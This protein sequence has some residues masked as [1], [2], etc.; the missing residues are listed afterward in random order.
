MPLD[1]A[2]PTPPGRGAAAASSAAL[3]LV[4]RCRALPCADG[5][6][7]V[8]AQSRAVSP[9]EPAFREGVAALHNFEYED[10]NAAFLRAQKA[11]PG[12]AMAYWGEAMTYH[13]S[14]WR[15]EDVAAGR[16][17]LARLAARAP[18]AR[19]ATRRTATERGFSAPR[20]SSSAR[21]MPPRAGAATPRRWPRL[22]ASDARRPRR[23]LALRARAARHDVAQPDRLRRTAHEGHSAVARRQRDADA[24]RRDS[25]PACCGRTREHPGALHY[26]LH[27]Y[28]DP[29]HARLGLDAARA[30][31]RVA[32]ESS[33]ALHM[34]AH[35]FL[36]LGMWAD[37]E[38]LGSRRLRR[39]GGVGRSARGFAPAMRSYHALAW[40]QYE[41]LQLGRFSEAAAAHRRDR[42]GGEGDRR[43]DAAER[44][45]LDARALRGRDPPLGACM[46]SERNFGN[47]NELCAIGFSAAR[48]GNPALAE[49]ARGRRWPA[50]PPRPRKATCGRPSPSWSAR[51]R[52]D[53]ARRP[54]A[55]TRRSQ[56][57]RAATR[58]RAAAAAAAGP[59]DPDQARRRS[60]SARCCSSWAGRPRRSTPFGAG[61][62]AQRQPHAV[63]A[64]L[65]PGRGARSGRPTRRAGTTRRCWPT[66]SSADADLP[67][68]AEARA[69]LSSR[70]GAAP[71]RRP[72]GRSCRSPLASPASSVAAAAG[73][74]RSP[75][76]QRNRRSTGA[77]PRRR[78]ANPPRKRKRR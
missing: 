58:R 9:A 78:P 45:V 37:A 35:I 65:G 33:H 44:P 71:A 53:R 76:A 20:R 1:R 26:L 32:P 49:L 13:Q 28:D 17:A 57:L 21:A 52:P 31:A 73:A 14:L 60:C 42:A 19:A 55:A 77:P 11:D 68:L 54:A 15:N 40:R 23:R 12:F 25:R 22:H 2:T 8:S 18:A 7:R 3:A 39:L 66:T 51:W 46:A 30:Y 74:R 38:A 27:N 75:T 16:R 56:I 64:R 4:A 62:G 24:R 70:R 10:A 50:G 29:A 5:R 67:E 6:S 61:A 41:L 63:G 69:A 43:S 72:A 34:P 48:S 47:V 36:Q 59:A